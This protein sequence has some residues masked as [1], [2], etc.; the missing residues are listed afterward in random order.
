MEFLRPNGTNDDNYVRFR[1]SEDLDKVQDVLFTEFVARYERNL[2]EFW[3]RNFIFT[4]NILA[5]TFSVDIH[6]ISMDSSVYEVT[7]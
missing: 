3:N 4:P 1:H 7:Q 6:F 2:E 5:Y